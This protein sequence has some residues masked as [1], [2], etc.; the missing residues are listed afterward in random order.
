MAPGAKRKRGDRT[1]SQESN[2]NTSRPSPHRPQS[3]GLAQ[4]QQQHNSARGGGRRGNRPGVGRGGSSAPQ[5]PAPVQAS[6][7]VMSPPAVAPPSVRTQQPATPS[8][9]APPAEQPSPTVSSKVQVT[10]Q[11]VTQQRVDAWAGMGRAAVVGAGT[12]AEAEGDMLTLSV[13][14]E[15]LVQACLDQTLGPDAIGLAVQEILA[16]PALDALDPISLFLETVSSLAETGTAHPPLRPMLESSGVDTSR[17]RGELESNLLTSLNLVRSSFSRV[18]IRKATHALYR[19]S[20]YN[21]LREETEGYSKLITDYFTTVN[22]RPPN[23]EVVTDTFERVKALIGAFD[24]DVGRVLDVT[25]DVFANLLVKHNKFFVKFLRISSWWPEQKVPHGIEWEEN[26]ISALPQWALPESAVWYYSDEG[27]QRQLALRQ[28]R[29]VEFWK[30]VGELIESSQKRGINDY[31]ELGARRITSGLSSI[32]RVALTDNTDANVGETPD[33]E[34]TQKWSEEWMFETG[35]LS[36]SGNR[37][38]AQLLG[39]KLRFYASDAR[40]AHDMLP[41][42]LIHLAALLIKIGFISLADLYPHLYPLDEDMAAHKE[43]LMKIKKEKEDKLRGVSTNA[44]AMAGALPDDTLPVPA[45]VSRLREPEAKPSSKPESERGTPDRVEEDSK[46]KLPEPVDQKTALLRSLLLIGAIPEALFIISRFPWLLEVYP[47][48]HVYVFRLL[49]HSLIKVYDE[50]RPFPKETQPTATKGG[51]NP[52]VPQT[53]NYPPR[54]TLRWAKLEEKDAG[55]GVD[56]RFYWEDWM[57]NVPICQNVDDVFKLRATL[58]G[59]IGVEIGLDALLLTKLA[60]IGKKSIADDSSTDNRLRWKE[61]CSELLAPALSFSGQNP[62][63]VNEVWDLLKQF[64]TAD[65][66]CIYAVWF[67]KSIRR[68]PALNAKFK[69]AETETKGLLA[70]MSTDNMRPMARALAKVACSC[71]GIVFERALHAI[72]SYPNLVDVLVECSRYFTYLAYDCLTWSLVT[73][74]GRGGRTAVQSDGMLTRPWLKNAAIFIGKVYKRYSLMD[75]TPMLQ[76]LISQLLQGK[77]YMLAVLEQLITS[78][79]GIG[80]NIAL[81]EAQVL[82]ISAGPLLKAFTLETYLGDHRHVSKNSAKRLLRCLKDVGLAPQY[83]VL[84]AMELGRYL[85]REDLDNA[86]L[87]VIGSNFDNLHSNFTQYLD[88]LR[89]NL[90]TSEFDTV[91]PSIVELLSE[92]NIDPELAFAI[93]RDSLSTQFRAARTEAKASPEPSKIELGANISKSE[94]PDETQSNGDVVM[95]DAT[96]EAVNGVIVAVEGNVQKKEEAISSIDTKIQQPISTEDVEMKDS[97]K[98]P[99]SPTQPKYLS[100]PAIDALASRLRT[101]IPKTYGDHPFLTFYITFW[102]LSLVDL[103]D[104]SR[105]DGYDVAIK[106]YTDREHQL[107]TARQDTT[108]RKK[109]AAYREES[110]KLRQE[111]KD[112]TTMAISTRDS[113]KK[114]MH[115]WFDG[116]PMVEA[117]SDALHNAILQDCFLPRIK[118]SSQDAQFAAA[119]LKFMHSVGVPGFRTMKFLDQLFRQKLLSSIIF[120]CTSRE[121]QNFGRFLNDVLKDLKNWHGNEKA[122]RSKGHGDKKRL[123]GF[124]RNFN[125]DRTP[126]TFL[127][128]EDF[129]RLLYKWHTQIFRAFEICLKSDDYMH[130]RNAINVLKAIAPTFPMVDSMGKGIHQL[131]QNVSQSDP[132]ED[133]K[134]TAL[135]LFGD[136]KKG[137]KHWITAQAF[138]AARVPPN[139]FYA[140]SRVASEQP[141]TPQTPDANPATRLNANAPEFMPKDINTNGIPKAPDNTNTE[142]EDGEVNDDRKQLMD[143]NVATAPRKEQEHRKSTPAPLERK[144]VE[145]SQPMDADF[146]NR[147]T[148]SPQVTKPSLVSTRPEPRSIASHP[149]PPT[150]VQHALPN[151][152]ESQPQQ[153][154]GWP[155]PERSGE[156]GPDYPT[157]SRNDTRGG[158]SQEYGRLD[159]PSDP[160]RDSFQDRREQSPGRR[161]RARSQERTL[162]PVDRRDPGWT[163]RDSR[164]YHDDRSMRPPPRDARAP[165]PPN[166]GPAWGE[167]PRESRDPRDPRDVRDIRDRDDLRG[168]PPPPPSDNRGRLHSNQPVL[169]DDQ[170]PYRRDFSHKPQQGGERNHNFSPRMSIDRPPPSGPPTPSG[171]RSLMNP[172]RAA[173]LESGDRNRGN[174]LRTEREAR[175]DRDSRPQSPRR[176]DERPPAP[177]H[178][179]NDLSRDDRNAERALHDRTPPHPYPANRDR[180]EEP[181]GIAPTGPRGPRIDTPISTRASRDMFQ[182]S[183]TSRA[184]AYQTQDPNYGRLNP[185]TESS[186]PSGPRGHSD[187]RDVPALLPP[188]AAPNAATQPD[189]PGVHPSR[190]GQINAPLQT[191]VPSA[192]SG[193]RNNIRT[194]QGPAASPT[195]RGPPTGP[196]SVTERNARNQDWSI[197]RTLNSVLTQNAPVAPGGSGGDRNAQTPG[198]TIRGRGANRASGPIEPSMM[199]SSTASRSYPSTPNPLRPEEHHARDRAE[200][201]A[202]RLENYTPDEGRLDSRGHTRRSERSGRHRS[203]STD[204]SDRRPDDRVSRNGPEDRGGRSD[205][206]EKAS[207]RERGSGREKRG[208]ERDSGRRDRDRDGDRSIRDGRDRRERGGRDEGR[209][210]ARNEG[211]SSARGEDLG[212]RRPP[213]ASG[214]PPIWQSDGRNESR[215]GDIRGRGGGERRD[216]R[217]RRNTRDDGRDGRKRGRGPEELP[218]GDNK[219]PR[220]SMQ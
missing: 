27:K 165:P 45:P 85:Y 95:G 72:E 135:S 211:R 98:D 41:D 189:R 110:S 43:N 172:D 114:E 212:S 63:V 194:P 88:F 90:S 108:A 106:H 29:D 209:N 6:P 145:Q 218:H 120:M 180:R 181:T 163:G 57:D 4:S 39:F 125:P 192:P 37:I 107:G 154:R 132:R 174:S 197:A 58:L 216:D 200:H 33:F 99:S 9:P 203:R 111:A 121:S 19:Q 14:F 124:A 184:P 201:T 82:G 220:R 148:S 55:D 101:V 113:L 167:H 1:Y 13:I 152:P 11:Y 142:R 109:V 126:A 59:L 213:L 159:R 166:R 195:T 16:A 178:G 187:R 73:S 8:A 116:F 53:S 117:P 87:K 104:A 75:P 51:K 15:E 79:G 60:R 81:T 146:N 44:L 40:D 5:S 170:G 207:D 219:R 66:Y 42:N 2:E 182:P 179:R 18:A 164:E 102:Q 48:L 46:E 112:M 134:L 185:P 143:S 74:L 92:Y 49:H 25:L 61:F 186:I 153:P 208:G 196:A 20:N 24:L 22:N 119:M 62:G 147:P 190:L 118:L 173:L 130:I 83:V 76:F 80:P 69:Q 94:S 70:R 50:S 96:T 56:Y 198:H 171:D 77:T 129:R 131:V 183:H 188:S 65:R 103:F 123:P 91:F 162:G 78:M 206:L 191:N 47:D 3:L 205:E 175:R 139:A 168:P 214:E 176:G 35:T 210:D 68:Q 71:P 215:S 127:E 161:P 193:P 67:G 93:S 136:I 30:R 28:Q 105:M 158:V 26:K 38:A 140:T 149:P 32:D 138:S 156:R 115:Q 160:M 204:R 97:P 86:P 10:N 137:E 141:G 54:R 64:D 177:Y 89:T 157:H 150:R 23:L 155:P 122:Y 128:Y 202:G 100:N 12:A 144:P 34:K 52:S 133:L 7:T 36:P 169:S 21:L 31:F 84:L 217:D 17:M 199:P 151:R